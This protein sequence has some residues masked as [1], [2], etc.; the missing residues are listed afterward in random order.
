MALRRRCAQTLT[1]VLAIAAFP[2]SANTDSVPR[3]LKLPADVSVSIYMPAQVRRFHALA[4]AFQSARTAEDTVL[5]AGQEY[6][7]RSVMA[8]PGSDDAFGLLLSLHPEFKPE[9]G[10]L[11]YTMEYAVFTA[12]DEPVLKGS[13]TVQVDF[14]DASGGGPIDNATLQAVKQVMGRVVGGLRPDAAKYP[15]SLSLKTR[16]LEFAVKKDKPW[17][18]GTGFYFNAAGQVLTAAHVI[19]DCAKIEIQRDD[20]T[21]VGTV[22][23]KSNVID[24]AALETGTPVQK[25]LPFRR[26]LNLEL[27]EPITNVGFPLQDILSSSPNVTRGNISARGGL[28]GSDGQIQ[29]SAP[30][31]PGSSGGPVVSD[32][33]EL[34]GIAVGTLN[35]A[36]LVK[37]GVIPQN[38]NFALDARYAERFLEKNHLEFSSV[39]ENS[40]GDIHTANQAALAAVVSVRCYE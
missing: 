22:L 1:V 16:S 7:A 23:A 34:L 37:Q 2:A 8:E 10:H 6:F 40:H 17:A 29:F 19:Q 36:A 12:A 33:G 3:D 15:P 25:F 26:G 39:D 24:V 18:T 30:I 11:S 38:V 4:G 35:A 27:G 20:K 32:S 13:E 28:K 31:Q 5:S 9:S 21:F 14:G